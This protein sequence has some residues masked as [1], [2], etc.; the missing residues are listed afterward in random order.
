[1]AGSIGPR[2][3]PHN[4]ND[5]RPSSHTTSPR[6]THHS[7]AHHLTHHLIPLRCIP[8]LPMSSDSSLDSTPPLAAAQRAYSVADLAYECA[9]SHL[10]AMC[11]KANAADRAAAL[12]S[13]EHAV[14]E[15][16][17]VAAYSARGSALSSVFAASTLGDTLRA[18]KATLSLHRAQVHSIA[19]ELD[20]E[21]R[22]E[23]SH[24]PIIEAIFTLQSE[25]LRVYEEA[26]GPAKMPSAQ[27]LEVALAHSAAREAKLKKVIGLSE[28][29]ANIVEAHE[30]MFE[31]YSRGLI[32]ALSESQR[33]LRFR[34]VRVGVLYEQDGLL[35]LCDA[36]VVTQTVAMEA[37]WEAIDHRYDA[38]NEV[39]TERSVA[40]RNLRI[41]AAEDTRKAR[42]ELAE[43]TSEGAPYAAVAAA[44]SSTTVASAEC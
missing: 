37:L 15:K 1:M 7:T 3:R 4:S 8:L 30:P 43:V 6:T 27:K 40:R 31:A 24:A 38:L 42:S 11:A 10:S 44:A 36:M 22:M 20:I 34:K 9:N 2:P 33:R 12:A 17:L 41:T 18:T 23:Q 19:D 14:A 25:L 5:P 35:C 29:F 32:H 13:A 28:P 39:H 21:R 16:Y 26:I